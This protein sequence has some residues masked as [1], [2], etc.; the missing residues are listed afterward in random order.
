MDPA[1][2]LYYSWSPYHYVRNNPIRLTDPNGMYDDGFVIDEEGNI[3]PVVDKNGNVDKTGGDSYD[4]LWTKKDYENGERSYDYKGTANTGIRIDDK[5]FIPEL[6]KSKPEAVQKDVFDGSSHQG[7]YAEINK[8]QALN[9]FTFLADA[10]A[11]EWSL[12][13]TTN[14]KFA[15]GRLTNSQAFDFS[16]LDQYSDLSKHAIDI[17][18]HPN[19]TYDD[20]RIS[21]KDKR[22]AETI[23][24]YNSSAKFYVYMPMLTKDN[25]NEVMRNRYINTPKGLKPYPLMK[26]EPA[27]KFFKY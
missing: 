18:S 3:S 6:R 7:Y 19:A 5:E 25:Y 21:G 26:Q 11:I 4:V 27:T 13:G 15:I 1:S 12:I 24:K 20:F 17:H 16:E 8:N 14:N 23:R 2:E 22:A 9:V 10:V